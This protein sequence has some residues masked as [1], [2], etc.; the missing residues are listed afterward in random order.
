[1]NS[2]NYLL[3]LITILGTVLG[4]IILK[5]GQKSLA[6]PKTWSAHHILVSAWH[7]FF[8]IYFLTALLLAF[9]GALSWSLIIQKTALSLAYPFMALSYVLIVLIGA[10]FFKEHI[11]A[12]QLFGIGL[13][14]AGVIFIGTK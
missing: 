14:I 4:Q 8:N 13:I 7:N 10:L 1:M 12:Y 6:Y 5:Y 9:I 2:I 11:S 3:I